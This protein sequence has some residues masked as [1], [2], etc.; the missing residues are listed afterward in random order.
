MFKKI[1]V[2]VA[3][4]HVD[5]MTRTLTVATDLARQYQAS[6]TFVGVAGKVPNA[7]ARSPEQFASALAAFAREQGTQAGIDTDSLALLSNDPAA[8]LDARLL[9][10][11]ETTQADLVVMGSHP[12]GVADTLHLIGSHSASLVRK[13]NVS[14][15]VVR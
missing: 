8:E 12:P 13:S 14:V 3:L 1:M 7:I 10:A 4:R 9:K 6:I 5:R 11:V 15:C 2:P